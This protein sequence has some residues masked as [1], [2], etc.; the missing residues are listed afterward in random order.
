MKRCGQLACGE[1]WHAVAWSDG[2]RRDGRGAKM[3]C[4]PTKACSGPRPRASSA[5]FAPSERCAVSAAEAERS[6]DITIAARPGGLS[7]DAG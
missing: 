1:S 4:C 2:S 6:T 5:G 3:T 7:T